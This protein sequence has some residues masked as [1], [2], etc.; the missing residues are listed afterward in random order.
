VRL[1]VAR[2][3]ELLRKRLLYDSNSIGKRLS[4]NVCFTKFLSD[5]AS[6]A[7]I[8][9]QEVVATISSNLVLLANA[10]TNAAG[11][12]PLQKTS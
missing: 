5:S 8:R 9:A 4:A 1:G 3:F 2:G 12:R 10:T 6:V 7:K 11:V